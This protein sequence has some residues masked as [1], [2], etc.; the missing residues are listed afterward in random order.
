MSGPWPQVC[1]GKLVREER[2]PAGAPDGN[3]LPVFG[4]TNAAGV[5]LTGIEASSDRSK[6][7]R[8]RPG[9]FVYNPYRVNVGSLGLSSAYQDGIVSPAYVVFAPTDKLVPEYLLHF[10]KSPRGIQ[11]INFFGNRGTVRSAL[12]FSDLCRIEIPLPPL[13][14]QRRIVELLGQLANRIAEARLLQFS[15][16]AEAAAMMRNESR[17]VFDNLGD[18]QT[19][20]LE[21]VCLDIVDC[22][23]SNP[24]YSDEGVPTIRSPDVGWGELF[25]N[26]ARRTSDEEFRRRTARSEPQPNDIIIVR[27]GGGTGKAGMVPPGQRLSLGQRVMQL[28]ADPSIV[29]PRYLLLYWLSPVIQDDHIAVFTKGSASPHLNIRFARRFPIR[30]PSLADQRDVVRR[31]DG[32]KRAVASIETICGDS[33]KGMEMLASAVLTR[34]LS[35]EPWFVPGAPSTAKNRGPRFS[36]P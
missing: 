28:R 4:V 2:D 23:H 17:C 21:D 12:R 35:G 22:L 29:E 6:Y 18:C 36:G 5:C 9:R 11:L 30:T 10:L 16:G 25:L 3:G 14:E 19:M 26:G 1:L 15:V 34:T 20:A 8:L 33:L 32:I 24:I 13:E 7:L 31:L 27:E